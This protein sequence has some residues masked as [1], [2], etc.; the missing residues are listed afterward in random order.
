MLFYPTWSKICSTGTAQRHDKDMPHRNRTEIEQTHDRDMPDRNRTD[1]G[2]EKREIE[3][4]Y[5]SPDLLS[6]WWGI[7]SGPHLS[8][9]LFRPSREIP[10]SLPLKKYRTKHQLA[11]F[12]PSPFFL[13]PPHLFSYLRSLSSILYLHS[14]FSIP[15]FVLRQCGVFKCFCK[16]PLASTFE[17]H[18]LGSSSLFSILKFIS[19]SL[20]F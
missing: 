6:P 9:C 13:F 16:T 11:P 2:T 20:Y 4:T 14:P 5:P 10:L 17:N 1:T 15:V 18:A 12:P 8:S 3:N 19:I 7:Q